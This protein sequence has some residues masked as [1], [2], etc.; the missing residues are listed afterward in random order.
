MKK[1][2]GKRS[3]LHGDVERVFYDMGWENVEWL[4]EWDGHDLDA[5]HEILNEEQYQ[6]LLDELADEDLRTP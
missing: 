5:L 4:E 1:A 2:A 3:Q 6:T